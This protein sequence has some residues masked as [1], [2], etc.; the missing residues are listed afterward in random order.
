MAI[1][2]GTYNWYPI[3]SPKMPFRFLQLTNISRWI[4]VIKIEILIND[5]V[6][7]YVNL[8]NGIVIEMPSLPMLLKE[9]DILTNGIL[10]V[11]IYTVF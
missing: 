11:V 6:I 1:V 10:V 5:I 9:H 7:Q 3:S 4:Y 8:T 2:T